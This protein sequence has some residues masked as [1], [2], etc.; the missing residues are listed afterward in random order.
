MAKR[1]CIR[2]ITFMENKLTKKQLKEFSILFGLGFPIIFGF[3][4]P[5]LIGHSFR[6]W[7][8]YIGIIVLFFGFANPKSLKLPYRLW[9]SLGNLLSRIN[10][11][12]IIGLVYALVVIP[13][14]LIMKIFSYDPLKLRKIKTSTYKIKNENKKIDLNKI[15]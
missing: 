6:I 8:L 14:G 11:P 2:L 15:F 3:L 10:G 1:I 7:T 9:M 5:F 4:V 12:I 13:I